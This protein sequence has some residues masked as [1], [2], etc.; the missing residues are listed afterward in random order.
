MSYLAIHRPHRALTVTAT[1]VVE[2]EN[3][4]RELSLFEHC[5]WEQA[6]AAAR[7][8][9]PLDPLDALQ[10]ALD[11][12]L[13]TAS[14]EFADYAATTFTPGR[15][16]LDAVTEICHRIN[17]DFEYKPGSTS[18]RTSLAEVFANREGVCQDFAHIGIACLRAV[19][20]PARYV[21]GYLETDPP[22]GRAKL[23]GVDGSHA[24]MSVLIPRSRLAGHRSD[25]QPVHERPLR[26]DRLRTRLQRRTA[27]QR[28]DL[29][30]G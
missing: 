10:Y 8:Q 22:P 11:S 16:L 23:K 14:R 6:R 26:R 21:S 9:Q 18:V 1:S 28:R 27:T 30:R 5:P 19:G 15:P 29:H 4:P 7:D 25:Q 17:S 3:Q 12:P 13:V 24:W 20:L 2:V